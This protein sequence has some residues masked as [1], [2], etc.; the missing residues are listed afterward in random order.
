ME[1]MTIIVDRLRLYAYHGVGV[2]ERVVGNEFE[3][4]VAVDYPCSGNADMLDRTLNYAEICR[5]VREESGTPSNLLE[6]LAVRIKQALMREFPLI[7]GGRI[8]VSKPSP[9]IGGVQVAGVGVEL[10]W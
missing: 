1:R 4:S 9:P 10:A 2:Q 8:R 6:H 3:V 5:I 7:T